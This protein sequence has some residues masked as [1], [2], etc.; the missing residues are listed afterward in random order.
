[1]PSLFYKSQFHCTL[2]KHG[3]THTLR[4]HIYIYELVIRFPAQSYP[5]VLILNIEKLEEYLGKRY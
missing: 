2:H 3:H 4:V 1:M 5:L